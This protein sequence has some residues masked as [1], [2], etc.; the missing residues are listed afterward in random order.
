M[1]RIGLVLLKKKDGL[2]QSY[3]DILSKQF[4]FS[5]INKAYDILKKIPID[6]FYLQEFK[7]SDKKFWN[8]IIYP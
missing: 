4:Q 8:N 2:Y 5:E 6:P 7:V 1:H 3:M